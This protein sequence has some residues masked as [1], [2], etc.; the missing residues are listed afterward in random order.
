MKNKDALTDIVEEA[1][2]S[3]RDMLKSMLAAGLP[4]LISWEFVSAAKDSSILKREIPSGGEFIPA[5]GLGTSDEFETNE[6]QSLEQLREVLRRFVSMGG[7]VIDTAP[8]YDNAEKMIGELIKGLG[9]GDKLFIATK[10]LS[11]GKQA[12]LEQMRTSERLLGI[13]PLDLMQVHS[14][15][16]VQTQLKNLRLWKDEGRVRYIGITHHSTSAHDEI[17][18][19]MRQEKLDFVQVNYSVTEPDAE[20]RLLPLAADKK[21]AV[22]VNRPFMNG[23]LFSMTKG[24]PLPKWAGEFDCSSWAQFSLKYI[25]SNPRVT[26]VIPATSNP[27][28]LADNMEAGMGRLP[29]EKTRRR[30]REYVASL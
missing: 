14:L 6:G 9:I 26:C 1:T 3:R 4:S 21:I 27:K 30:M 24:K 19:L 22:I 16:D 7:E 20:K 10:V 29:D 23:E 12:G 15:V 28:H 17:E 25:L 11:R 8:I 5:V 2:I 18:R 13:R